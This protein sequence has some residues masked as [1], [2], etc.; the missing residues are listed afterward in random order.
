MRGWVVVAVSLA[1]AAMLWA[2]PLN[3][4]ESTP[5]IFS[6]GIAIDYNAETDLFSATGFAVTYYCPDAYGITGGSFQ[7]A[8]LIDENASVSSGSLLIQGA[9]TGGSGSGN[10][11]TLLTASNVTA[12]GYIPDGSA[13]APKFEFLMDITG[14]A[15]APDFLAKGS[16]AGVILSG[17][18]NWEGDEFDWKGNFQG[19]YRDILVV[20]DTVPVP[21]A[22][23]AWVMAAAAVIVVAWA[24]YYRFLAPRRAHPG[25][26]Q[27]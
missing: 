3:L 17:F 16:Q 21:E 26:G 11:E 22:G 5:D 27:A 1:C 6:C 14:G 7:L 24:C 9:T 25:T 12:F 4:P 18:N 19:D 15:L 10:F 2:E 8:A 13:G 20:S 23:S